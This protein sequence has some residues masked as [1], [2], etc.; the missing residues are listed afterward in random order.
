M[1]R[2]ANWQKRDL[3]C[4]PGPGGLGAYS[5]C[6]LFFLRGKLQRMRKRNM[7]PPCEHGRWS[8]MHRPRNCEIW[9]NAP[10]LSAL[11]KT[12]MAPE[13]DW[14]CLKA[15][16]GPSSCLK[17]HSM[18][19]NVFDHF[20][21]PSVTDTNSIFTVSECMRHVSMTKI[22]QQLMRY[23]FLERH[24]HTPCIHVIVLHSNM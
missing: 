9:H 21:F 7:R 19:L 12:G 11:R 10:R 16:Q 15:A 17:V 6:T 20:A 14:G 5:K 4:P 13:L 2:A 24:L 3:N 23:S 22:F 1:N 8:G 18:T